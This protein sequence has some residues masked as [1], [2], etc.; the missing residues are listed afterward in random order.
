MSEK[1]L[2]PV[3]VRALRGKEAGT[4]ERL[5]CQLLIR[6]NASDGLKK[7]ELMCQAFN[8]GKSMLPQNPIKIDE[9][10]V[11][12]IEKVVT[13][14]RNAT[15]HTM[16]SGR[17]YYQIGWPFQ[18]IPSKEAYERYIAPWHKNL[19]IQYY[20]YIGTCNVNQVEEI[21]KKWEEYLSTLEPELYFFCITAGMERW[22]A[23]LSESGLDTLINQFKVWAMPIVDEWFIELSKLVDTSVFTEIFRT[24]YGEKKP[25]EG[26]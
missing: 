8:R 20:P 23:K 18:I 16:I 4:Y 3:E 6:A 5:L 17:Q 1:K 2:P 13:A 21:E 9:G 14:L 22:G 10:Q 15:P 7:I 25:E 26:K 19:I 24:M 12:I 11:E